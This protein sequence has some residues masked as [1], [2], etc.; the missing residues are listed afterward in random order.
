MKAKV[1][2]RENYVVR[3]VR[4]CVIAFLCAVILMALLSVIIYFSGAGDEITEKSAAMI[5]YISAA[6]AAFLCARGAKGK[7]FL[8]GAA[9]A[10]LYISILYL[11]GIAM[12]GNI[13]DGSFAKYIVTSGI[14]GAISGIA[15]INMK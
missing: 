10:V 8:C 14:T 15:G 4:A 13:P 11:A 2:K 1:V 5:K 9:A 12:C 3:C 6:I 7:G